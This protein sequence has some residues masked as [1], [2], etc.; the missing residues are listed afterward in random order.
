MKRVLMNRPAFTTIV[1]VLFLTT[2]VGCYSRICLSQVAP[3][4]TSGLAPTPPMG[5]AS[6]NHYFCDYNEQTIRE[7]ADALVSTGMRDAGYKY[8]LIQECI[9]LKRDPNGNLIADA[10]R[11]PSGMPTL[12]AYIHKLG[13]KAGT[14]T[15]IGLNTCFSEPRYQGSYGHEQQDAN[16]F[17]AWGMD[18]VEMDYCNGVKAHTGKWVYERMAQAIKNT[19]RPMLFYICSWGNESPW[20]WAQGLAQLWRTEVDISPTKDH[21]DWA[22]IVQLFHSNATHA[23]FNA[24]DNW[25]DP[26]MLEVGNQGLS[27][28]EARAHFSM[29]AISGAPLWAGNDVTH[30]DAVIHKIYTNAEVIAVDQDP[31]GAGPVKIGGDDGLEV[32]AK[33]LGSLGSG[34]TAVLL[35]NLTGS[36]AD[37][38]VPLKNL[39]VMAN[40]TVHDL[41]AGKDLGQFSGSYTARIPSHGAVMLKVNGRYRWAAGTTYEAEWPGN[42]RTNNTALLPCPECSHGY[43]VALQGVKENSQGSSLRFTH[44]VVPA[45]G[46]YDLNITYVYNGLGKKTVNVQTNQ[47]DPVPVTL[48]YAIYANQNA[49]IELHQGDNSI[50]L[51]FSGSVA[52]NIDKIRISQEGGGYG[53]VSSTK[54]LRPAS[55]PVRDGPLIEV[56]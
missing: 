13:L 32:W 48:P 6:W 1:C 37:I 17:A 18:F 12:T 19:G 52:V 3:A 25:N 7:Q 38:D 56:K 33:P 49:P 16:T 2:V 27:E 5:W 23:V 20:L 24:P 15:D 43:S 50:L 31:L 8:I 36:A 44:I 54:I 4:S 28:T 21:A 46:A 41:W 39:G 22:H 35:L 34:A 11:F 55:A 26:D 45:S 51:T 42:I 30:M 9:S 29:W 14:Y 10:A 47:S 40:A 53:G